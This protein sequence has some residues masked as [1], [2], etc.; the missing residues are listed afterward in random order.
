MSTGKGN[1]PR[2][3]PYRV[4]CQRCGKP[5]LKTKTAEKYCSDEC[6]DDV[7]REKAKLAAQKRKERLAE[8]EREEREREEQRK[9]EE[10]AR[11]QAEERAKKQAEAIRKEQ[12]KPVVRELKTKAEP[13][14]IF[15]NCARCGLP[16]LKKDSPGR[17]CPDCEKKLKDILEKA[18]REKQRQHTFL[19]IY[20]ERD[21]TCKAAR[22]CA[23]GAK[24][25]DGWGCGYASIMGRCRSFGDN[26]GKH[27]IFDGKCD[28]Y[29]RRRRT[30][31]VK[32]EEIGTDY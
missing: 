32:D 13:N 9:A 23:Y 21:Y 11:K 17:Y 20:T 24:T 29:R 18:R 30:E 5:F 28:L 14:S 2:M 12:T 27:K 22:R 3:Q 19:R 7:R 15:V 26:Y 10:R 31:V 25:S 8:I 16:M 6:R 4:R 1:P